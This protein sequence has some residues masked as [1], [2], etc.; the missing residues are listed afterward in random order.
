MNARMR[1][2]LI[3]EAFSALEP[4]SSFGQLTPKCVFDEVTWP[5][6]VDV[7]DKRLSFLA[8]HRPPGEIVGAIIAHDL[9]SEYDKHPYE[10]SGPPAS[11]G[12][13]DLLDEMADM[14]VRRDFSQKSKPHMVLHIWVGATRAQH[15]G[16]GVGI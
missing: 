15:L 2:Q 1:D 14:F 6:M 7:L 4:T 9:Y 16:K 10:A 11:I 13:L 3:A 8:Q 5:S 12:I